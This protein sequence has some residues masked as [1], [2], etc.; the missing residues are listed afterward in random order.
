[1]LQLVMIHAGLLH[2]NV[3]RSYSELVQAAV[4]RADSHPHPVSCG[5]YGILSMGLGVRRRVSANVS[6]L[7]VENE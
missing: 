5:S 7:K 4:S 6:R 2:I 1:M 3:V